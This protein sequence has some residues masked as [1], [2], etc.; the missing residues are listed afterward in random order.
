MSENTEQ[1]I[2]QEYFKQQAENKLM[3]CIYEERASKDIEWFYDN[4]S[5]EWCYI[6]TKK[7]RF[8]GEQEEVVYIERKKYKTFGKKC[9]IT[10]MSFF[11]YMAIRKLELYNTDSELVSGIYHYMN[12]YK[13]YKKENPEATLDDFNNK[14]KERRNS[15][16]C[17]FSFVGFI[18]FIGLS[19]YKIIEVLHA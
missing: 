13:K 15:G 11:N 5:D 10:E 19:I 4:I 8:D 12:D 14:I 3:L 18:G 17:L 6:K 2:V 7:E 9:H 16:G 1:T